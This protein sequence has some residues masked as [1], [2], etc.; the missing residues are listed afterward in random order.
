MISFRKFR[1]LLILNYRTIKS[2][3][4]IDTTL[5]N[6]SE[7]NIPPF[8]TFKSIYEKRA[9]IL[10]DGGLPNGYN[11]VFGK[12]QGDYY[13][14]NSEVLSLNH[15]LYLFK[16]IDVSQKMF[17]AYQDISIFRR[18]DK[19]INEPIYIGGNNP[20]AIPIDDFHDI[21]KNF[22]NSYEIKRYREARISNILNEYFETMSD[23]QSRFEKYLNKKKSIKYF[24]RTANI[25]EFETH[26]FEYIRD[27][28]KQMLGSATESGFKEVHWQKIISEFVLLLFPRYIKSLE[29]VSIKDDYTD[30]KK[31]KI[32]ELDFMLVDASGTIDVMELKQPFDNC[33]LTSNPSY[34]DNYILRENFLGL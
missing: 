1:D 18:I 16:N 15:P 8:F 12:L 22:P 23:A 34:R 27:E 4:W 19:L 9:E 21:L 28:L 3:R 13:K 7:V 26:K 33:I 25:D 31:P 20:N 6:K 24:S 29:K 32:R 30:P 17:I 5:T 10:S 2:M 11:F 14:V